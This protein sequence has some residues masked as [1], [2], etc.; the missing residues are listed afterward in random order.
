[1]ASLDV[2]LK[3]YYLGEIGSPKESRMLLFTQ[4]KRS[5]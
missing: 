4:E 1:V 3:L 2:T 5:G